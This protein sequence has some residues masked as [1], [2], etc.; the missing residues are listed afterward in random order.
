MTEHKCKKCKK[1]F[2][3]A[4]EH[5]YKDGKG[6]YCSWTFYLHRNDGKQKQR[7]HKYVE[8]YGKDR[9]LIRRFKS[10]SDAVAH[11]GFS[12]KGIW[13]ACRTGELYQG[14][15]WKYQEKGAQHESGTV[16]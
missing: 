13:N 10:V 4:P 14:F 2:I 8:I 3:P 7:K 6:T 1:N 11:T 9:E 12:D 5:I 15:Y 16:S